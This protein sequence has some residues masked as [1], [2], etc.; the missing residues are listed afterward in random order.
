MVIIWRCARPSMPS[1]RAIADPTVTSAIIPTPPKIQS[2]QYYYNIKR[3]N[4]ALLYFWRGGSYRR[5]EGAIKLR[6]NHGFWWANLF[7]NTSSGPVGDGL[8]SYLGD[9]PTISIAGSEFI[10]TGG[11]IRCVPKN[12][13]SQL[14]AVC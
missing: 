13:Q 9:T 1:C 5:S 10:Q 7:R 12:R 11:R 14:L 4:Y 6:D 8:Q 2:E 3:T